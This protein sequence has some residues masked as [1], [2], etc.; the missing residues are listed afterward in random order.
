MAVASG[1]SPTIPVSPAT[2]AFSVTATDHTNNAT[3]EQVL[4]VA[5]LL[6]AG[7]TPPAIAAH[8]GLVE[9]DVYSS[10]RAIVR[11]QPNPRYQFTRI[12]ELRAA[13]NT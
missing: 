12:S 3:I 4:A 6:H 1:S 10:M 9:D 7:K 11:A 13:L 2:P 5:R 8:L